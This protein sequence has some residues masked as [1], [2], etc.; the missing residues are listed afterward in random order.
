VE[1]IKKTMKKFK[2]LEIVK[3]R[4]HAGDEGNERADFLA[5]SAITHRKGRK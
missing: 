2:N 3:V 1:T 4:A 5:T